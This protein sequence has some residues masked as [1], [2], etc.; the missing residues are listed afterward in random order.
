MVRDGISCLQEAWFLER[1]ILS[2]ESPFSHLVVVGASAGGIEALSEG[3]IT[4]QDVTCDAEFRPTTRSRR[5]K[6]I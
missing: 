4:A 3:W 1:E 2:E 6:N 5:V